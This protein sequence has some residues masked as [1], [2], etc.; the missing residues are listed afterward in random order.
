MNLRVVHR[1]E[2]AYE[3]SVSASYGQIYL[4]P[5]DA[6]GQRVLSTRVDIDPLPDSFG[7]F[8]DFFGN[9][10]ANFSV[11]RRHR[12]LIVSTTSF[13]DVSERRPPA[14]GTVSPPWDDVV[15]ALDAAVNAELIDARQFVLASPAVPL[16]GATEAYA[17]TSFA[18]GRPMLD[19]LSDLTTRIHSDIKYKPGTTSLSTKPDDV[20]AERTGVCQDMA[21]LQVACLRSIGLAARY[22]SGYLETLPPPGKP[23]LQGADASHAWVSVYLPPLGWIDVDPTNDCF[24]GPRHITTAWGRDYSDVSPL[25]GVIFTEAKRNTMT[26]SVDVSPVE[27][28]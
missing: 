19:A 13:V 16:S 2:Y 9:Q 10:A 4:L 21:H 27:H 12:T 25:K 5:R 1:T 28:S 7:E 20:L 15:A 14:A 24:V 11:L 23:K 3:S 18:P 17:R 6:T 8:K 22:V 26:V